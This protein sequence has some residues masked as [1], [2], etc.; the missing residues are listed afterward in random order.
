MADT[1]TCQKC[2]KEYEVAF[3]GWMN[4]A[5]CEDCF[6]EQSAERP[7]S[8]NVQKTD[9]PPAQTSGSG[10]SLI[11]SIG[12]GGAFAGGLVGFL[13]RPAN[14]LLGQLPLETVITRGA[15]LRGLDQLLV[16]LAQKSF[17]ITMAGLVIG[18]ILGLG[19]GAIVASLRK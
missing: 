17:N 15:N 4:K 14:M 1:H 12:T 6:K 10:A 2:G 8:Q 18:A 7:A 11:L 5:V 9:S 3:S 13:L 19:L 16:P